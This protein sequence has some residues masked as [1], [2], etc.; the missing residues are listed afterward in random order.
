MAW[1]HQRL[2]ET[3][4]WRASEQLWEQRSPTPLGL[5]GPDFAH[6]NP[7]WRTHRRGRRRW[8]ASLAFERNV[9]IELT[10]LSAR[11]STAL[12]PDRGFHP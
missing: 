2:I 11:A 12:F 8:S 5:A 4:F 9:K 10:P 6:I 1:V 7:R 3:P